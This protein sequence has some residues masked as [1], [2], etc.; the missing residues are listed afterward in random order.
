[1]V[2]PLFFLPEACLNETPFVPTPE[3]PVKNFILRSAAIAAGGTVCQE[4]GVNPRT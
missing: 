3:E 4:E 1:M 2:L